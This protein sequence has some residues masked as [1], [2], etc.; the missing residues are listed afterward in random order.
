M[1]YPNQPPA[2]Q[3]PY[4]QQ[5][6]PAPKS[7]NGLGLAALIIGV[8][9]FV[10]AFIPFVNFVSGFLAFV[11]LVLGVIAIFLKGRSKGLAIAGA[12]ISFVAMILSIILAITYTAGFAGAVSE[13]IKTAQAEASVE[14]DRDVTVLY[15]VTGASTASSITY[16]TFTDGN[17]GTEQ[18]NDQV[19]PFTK[20]LTIK[21]GG[22]FDYSSFYLLAMNG[23]DDAGDISCKIT[24]DGQVVAEQTS[25]GAYAS[26]SCSA[27]SMDLE[28]S[29]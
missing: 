23:A 16:A 4:A 22:A 19:L 14:A 24:V 7:G 26:A 27:S 9:A 17:S 13:G 1:S 8:V 10:G 12:A 15:E 2:P 21:A 29:E 25:T 18:A 11:G 6:P 3:Q 28:D 20:E 5:M